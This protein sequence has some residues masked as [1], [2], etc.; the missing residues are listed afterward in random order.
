MSGTPP[1]TGYRTLSQDEID[2]MNEGKQ[3]G[4]LIEGYIAK[5][6]AA[7]GLTASIDMRWLSIGRTQLQQGLMALLR[8]IARPTT[9]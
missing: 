7:N 2:L 1:I 4:I 6:E 9:F 5:V 3:L 8:A